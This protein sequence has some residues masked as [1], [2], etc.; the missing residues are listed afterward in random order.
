MSNI[1]KEIFK[2]PKNKCSIIP[3]ISAGIPSLRDTKHVLENLDKYQFPLIELGFPYSDPLADGNIIQKA[4]QIAI[5]NNGIT[6]DSIFK[7]L[8]N[9]NNKI[10]T[11]IVAFIYYNQLVTYGI[12]KFIEKLSSRGINGLLVPDLPCEEQF[13]LMNLCKLNNIHLILLITPTSSLDRIKYLCSK[14]QGFIYL[15][16]RL[17]VTGFDKNNVIDNASLKILIKQIRFFTN[18]PIAIGFGI[19]NTDQ[20][21]QIKNLGVEGLIIGSA[22]MNILMN[23]SNTDFIELLS[24]FLNSLKINLE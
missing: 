23:N 10:N 24:K 9:I 8:F 22:C 7:I 11:P 1:S 2:F 20:I 12:K 19:S 6:I 18:I 14:A 3:F 15:V 17:G 5:Y 16:S 4:S 13:I 21:I